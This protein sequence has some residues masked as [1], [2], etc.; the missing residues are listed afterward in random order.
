MKEAEDALRDYLGPTGTRIQRSPRTGKARR[1]PSESVETDQ[2]LPRGMTTAVDKALL[3]RIGDAHLAFPE[4][5]QRASTGSS[6]L[7]KRGEMA[8]EGKVDWAF[9]ELLAP[10][11]S[12]P[13]AS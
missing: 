6:V 1:R 11:R 13:R 8:Y 5:L 10:V 9:A 12:C 4:G 3:A 7:E 2:M